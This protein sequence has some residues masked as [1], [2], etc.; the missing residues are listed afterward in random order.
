[1][2][3]DDCKAEIAAALGRELSPRELGAIG[4]QA[5][6]V[7]ARIDA[8]KGNTIAARA[9]M[10][11]YLDERA[12]IKQDK[13]T[14]AAAKALKGEQ[15]LAAWN[16]TGDFATKAPGQV[17]QGMFIES[18]KDFPGARNSLG[19]NITRGIAE[20]TQD[21]F[22]DLQAN[23]IDK[24]AADISDDRNQRLAFAAL[25]AGKDAQSFG[26]NAVKLATILKKHTD[27]MEAAKRAEGIPLGHQE[28]WAGP[29]MHDP[30][31]LARAGDNAF[32]SNA[33]REAWI[34]DIQNEFPLNWEKSFR[35]EF[36]AQSKAEQA[37]RLGEIHTQF[38]QGRHMQ[39]G[40]V[41]PGKSREL[42][43]DSPETAF[44]YHQKYGGNRTLMEDIYHHLSYGARDVAIARQWGPGDL[45]STVGQF[46]DARQKE[47][48]EGGNGK[49]AA[50]FENVR[51]KIV[52]NWIPSMTGQLGAPEHGWV[53][54]VQAFRKAID[55]ISIFG[56]APVLIGDIPL[57]TRLMQQGGGRAMQGYLASTA[58]TM[59]R[60]IG[61]SKEEKFRLAARVGIL[62]NDAQKPLTHAS[63]EWEGFGKIN[64]AAQYANQYIG[65]SPWTDRLR[66]NV[67]ASWA[68][69]HWQ[70]RGRTF[71]ELLPGQQ[72]LFK[73][74]GIGEKEW[75][76][77]RKQDA[78]QL[79]DKISGFSPL[80]VRQMDLQSFK[81]LAGNGASDASLRSARTAVADKYRNLIGEMAERGTSAPSESMKA[82]TTQGQRAGTAIGQLTR[83]FNELKNFTYNLMR[84]HLG[85]MIYGD[86]NPDNVG[87]GRA[88]M[89]FAKGEGG[90]A[91]AR[92]KFVKFIANSVTFGVLINQIEDVRDG[93]TP[94]IM[95]PEGHIGDILAR[96]F[97]RQSFGL[98]SDFVLAQ[99]QHPDEPLINNV[100]RMASGPSLEKVGDIGTVITRV[101]AHNEE[102]ATGAMDD[103]Q[104]WKAWG[105]DMNQAVRT[106]Y[107][108]IPGNNLVWTKW[109]TDRYLY[110][111]IQD[112]I[113]PGYKERLQARMAK[114][115]QT[116]IGQ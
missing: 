7:K 65:H 81:T 115:G 103:D 3:I 71:S 89:A 47:I 33:S 5:A 31:A 60:F 57:N 28:D 69:D 109:A 18:L 80:G 30:W 2:A 111:G 45:T 11:Q 19:V 98:Y 42:F 64:K 44:K 35:G 88:M 110:D 15:R 46:L 37:K 78:T 12:Q 105:G 95:N 101:L 70:D 10:K 72:Q 100:M 40:A 34:K 112:W 32:G 1:M 87:W 53:Q 114:R 38:V 39:Y 49:A 6:K 13:Q 16:A 77:I 96:G 108:M 22:T 67:A 83:S 116:Y 48:V 62:L 106:G 21:M 27:A 20:R 79:T 102:H 54:Y 85:Q 59:D 91:G 84:N 26:P 73:Q 86:S 52:N 50:D 23:K 56:S 66:L 55:T 92:V 82:I 17:A 104:F 14:I 107:G 99:A 113:N 97:L 90:V 93:K 29:Q 63:M 75:A 24:Y 68:E 43:F 8:A 36:L 4:R 74:F 41:E 9:I 25:Q 61:M 94:E 51:K 58:K 76:I